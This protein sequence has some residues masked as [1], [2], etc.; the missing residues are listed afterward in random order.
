MIKQRIAVIAFAVTLGTSAYAQTFNKDVLKDMQQ[1]GHDILE[2]AEGKRYM[3]PNNLC[4]D[5]GES[6]LVV[7][8]CSEA[9]SQVWKIDEQQHLVAHSGQ[10]VAGPNLAECG[11]GNAQIWKYDEKKRLA[12]ANSWCLQI[13]GDAPVAGA[14]VI[15]AQCSD[16]QK[17]VWQ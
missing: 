4:L 9:E 16:A 6:G 3:G 5:M 8:A 10:C 12:N 2:Q 1:Q 14:K 11:T 7:K 15:T 17:Q 13:S